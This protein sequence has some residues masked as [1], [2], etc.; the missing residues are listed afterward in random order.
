MA[1]SKTV[2]WH[3]D[4]GVSQL[5]IVPHYSLA[6]RIHGKNWPG[7]AIYKDARLPLARVGNSVTDVFK[8][9]K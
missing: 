1:G 7:V 6:T 2:N 5:P 4:S 8:S 3:V 9:D